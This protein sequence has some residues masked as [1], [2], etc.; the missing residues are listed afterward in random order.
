MSN[1]KITVDGM[2][3]MDTDP[4]KWRSTPPDI[5]DLKRQSGGQGWGLA[6]MVTL[7][8]AGTL[9]ELGQ[10][11]GNTTM[12]ITT[13]ANG[14]TL[15]VEQDGSEPSVAPAR[16]VP[17][18]TA[19]PAHAEADTSAGRQGFSSDVVIIEPYVAEARP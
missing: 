19:P 2:A 7:A 17:A 11:I 12:T 13:R 9:A 3:L 1:I 14:W 4:G 16:V 18:P 5:P 10:P 15:D 6:V 8:Q